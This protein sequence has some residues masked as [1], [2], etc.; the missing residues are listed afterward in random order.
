MLALFLDVRNEL[1]RIE[2]ECEKLRRSKDLFLTETNTE[3]KEAYGSMM[4]L[5]LHGVYVGVERVLEDILRYFDGQLPVGS[6]WHAKLLIRACNQNPG[7]REAVIKEG[8]AAE[9]GN[10]KSFRHLVRGIYQSSLNFDRVFSMSEYALKV[11]P[12]VI[13]DIE[14]FMDKHNEPA[15]SNGD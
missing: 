4:T 12:A 3:T 13:N 1:N 15:L 9:L 11:I 7:V 10:L 14:N 6:D 8:A 5:V 2:K